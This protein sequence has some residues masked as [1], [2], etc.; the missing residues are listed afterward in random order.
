M[1]FFSTTPITIDSILANFNSQV[2][3]LKLLATEFETAATR[4]QEAA[5]MALTRANENTREAERAKSV[6]S[7]IQ[8]LIS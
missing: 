3:D 2:E 8:A 5:A 4:E 7:K 1:K 6:A